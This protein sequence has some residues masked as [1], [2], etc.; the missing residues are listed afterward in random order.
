MSTFTPDMAVGE[1]AARIPLATRVFEQLGIDFCCGG[2][3]PLNAACAA[4]GL[5]PAAVLDRILQTGLPSAAPAVDWR[6]ASL[7][8]LVDHILATH[9][10][11]TK[12]QLPR[13][14]ALMEKVISKH[15]GGHPEL[16]QVAQVFRAMKEEL[17]SHLM[18]EET[19]LFPLIRHLQSGAQGE[20]FHCGTVQNPIHVMVMEHDSAGDALAQLRA[21]TADY[22]PPADGCN[23]F[24][25]LYAELA[26]LE[27]DLHQHIHLENNILFPRA[28]ALEKAH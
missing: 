21:L 26:D 9:H 13:I 16:A 2:R 18:K 17:G 8:S 19:I 22:T 4:Q 6:S 23:T 1:I 14:D 12:A 24:R 15:G 25:A 5:E 3:T 20:H 27:W 11:Y 7:D 28:I 10:V